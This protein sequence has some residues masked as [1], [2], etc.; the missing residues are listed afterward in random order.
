MCQLWSSAYG[1][2]LIFLSSIYATSRKFVFIDICAEY[3]LYC[4]A[5]IVSYRNLVVHSNK[6]EEHPLVLSCYFSSEAVSIPVVPFVLVWISDLFVDEA[7]SR[8]VRCST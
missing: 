1:N 2:K 7:I 5:H 8:K 6:N 3:C 4:A